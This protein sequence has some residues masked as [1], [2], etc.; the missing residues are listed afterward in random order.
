MSEADIPRY[1]I[2]E[3]ALGK[4]E[5]ALDHME[6]S[7]WSHTIPAQEI[8]HIVEIAKAQL[9]MMSLRRRRPGASWLAKVGSFCYPRRFAGKWG[10]D[11]D[12]HLCIQIE[13]TDGPKAARDRYV[14][15]QMTDDEAERLARQILSMVEGRKKAKEEG[16]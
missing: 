5:G 16:R 4:V 8:R 12:P 14:E 6:G 9:R 10:G 2:A 13:V 3:R 7:D 15:I 11:P 1:E